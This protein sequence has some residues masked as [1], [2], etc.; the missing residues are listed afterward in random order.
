MQRVGDEYH[1]LLECPELQELRNE[2]LPHFFKNNPNMYKYQQLM[3]SQDGKVIIKLFKFI[4]GGFKCI[5]LEL[6]LYF[7]HCYCITMLCTAVSI[8]IYM[9]S[10]PPREA[11]VIINLETKAYIIDYIVRLTGGYI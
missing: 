10:M 2:F 5:Y 11:R 9:Y 8:C 7:L 3:S 1:L 4:K 6:S